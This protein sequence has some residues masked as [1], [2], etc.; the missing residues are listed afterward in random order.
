M[1]N[2]KNALS[3]KVFITAILLAFIAEIF[4]A[5]ALPAQVEAK[6]KLIKKNHSYFYPE[7]A[8]I[9]GEC[10]NIFTFEQGVFKLGE[11]NG[12]KFSYECI[13]VANP[14]PSSSI[15]VGN[16]YQYETGTKGSNLCFGPDGKKGVWSDVIAFGASFQANCN[17][18]PTK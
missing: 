12:N 7:D 18:A 1:F 14:F 4:P 11:V 2:F 10:L 6:V 5:L 8:T 9:I 15:R 17:P 16:R 13:D 3:K